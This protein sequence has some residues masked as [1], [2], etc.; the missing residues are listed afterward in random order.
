[1]LLTSIGHALAKNAEGDMRK[2]LLQRVNDLDTVRF[3]KD[4]HHSLIFDRSEYLGILGVHGQIID[5]E[6][7]EQIW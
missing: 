1:M 4:T 7:S 2:R 6:I 5:Y 3:L